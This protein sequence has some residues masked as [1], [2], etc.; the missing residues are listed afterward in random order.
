MKNRLALLSNQTNSKDW[1][2]V[3]GIDNFKVY[4]TPPKHCKECGSH[5]IIC[6][7][8]L[9]AHKDCLFWEC[10]KCQNKYLRFTKAYTRKLLNKLNIYMI[11]IEDF[12]D[13][14]DKEPN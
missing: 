8:I 13:I 14:Q 7:E 6:L 2:E 3:M 12:V 5:K 1:F 9:G 10:G 11:N 4:K